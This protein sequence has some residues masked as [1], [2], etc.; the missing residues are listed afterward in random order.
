MP[1][2]WFVLLPTRPS[3]EIQNASLFNAPVVLAASN[4]SPISNP[5]TAP[6]EQIA[7]ARFASSFSNT[8]SPIPAGT[9]CITHS[10]IPPAES[11][12]AIFSSR[13][14][15]ASAAADASGIYSIFRLHSSIS[16]RSGCTW[17]FPIAFVYAV[18]L[19]PRPS[20]ILAATAPAATRPMVSRPEDLPPPR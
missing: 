5:F 11:I 15:C 1:P 17:I 2:A 18:T 4:P 20:R 10:T 9:P 6:I 12:C 16:N 7:L 3:G 13:N 8:G 19:T 14:I